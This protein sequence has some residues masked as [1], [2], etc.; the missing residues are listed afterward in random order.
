MEL[1]EVALREKPNPAAVAAMAQVG[2]MHLCAGKPETVSSAGPNHSQ[3]IRALRDI[4]VLE[5]KRNILGGSIS[6]MVAG[7]STL[8]GTERSKAVRKMVFMSNDLEDIENNITRVLAVIQPWKEVFDNQKGFQEMEENELKKLLKDFYFSKETVIPGGGNVGYLCADSQVPET[9]SVPGTYGHTN[10]NINA[11]SVAVIE[12]M[13]GESCVTEGAENPPVNSE[14][15]GS[16]GRRGVWNGKRLFRQNFSE[17]GQAS[18]R[19]NE[20]KINLVKERGEF[21]GRRFVAR[22]LI[23][24]ST[25]PLKMCLGWQCTVLSPLTTLYDEEGFW[26]G[27]WKVQVKLHI[28]FHVPK[29]LPNSFFIGK[30]CFYP[31]QHRVCFRHPSKECQEIRCNLCLKL[32]HA[33]RSCLDAWHNI[34][35]DCPN[36]QQEIRLW[37]RREVVQPES[38]APCS[39]VVGRAAGKLPKEKQRASQP[40]RGEEW[41]VVG[42][43]ASVKKENNPPQM[44]LITGIR[45]VLPEGKSWGDLAEEEEERLRDDEKREKR[46]AGVLGKRNRKRKEGQEEVLSQEEEWESLEEDIEIDLEGEESTPKFQVKRR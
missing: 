33:H 22:N 38:S 17:V 10:A 18:R 37:K 15:V 34:V 46:K 26:I 7:L 41:R 5:E 21:L 13:T 31:G 4:K 6:N 11:V 8:K 30:V 2:A 40:K 35:R 23:K 32:G 28:N 42:K 36:L 20:V 14:S 16:Q 39:K 44:V 29:H 43:K 19:K 1:A 3:I 12:N 25:L 24:Q 9:V 45:F 27:G